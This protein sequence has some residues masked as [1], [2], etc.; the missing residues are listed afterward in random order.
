MKYKAEHVASAREH[1]FRNLKPGDTVY[2]ILKH[3]SDSG[4]SRTIDAYVIRD[5][6]PVWIGGPVAAVL[7]LAYD[8][9][10]QGAKVSGAGMDMGFHLVYSLAGT[11][12]PGYQSPTPGERTTATGGY[13]L[14]QEWL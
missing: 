9:R 11:L 4:M 1:L 3:V 12:W 2:T 8:D 10:R 13:A 6:R 5:G 14:R 7:G